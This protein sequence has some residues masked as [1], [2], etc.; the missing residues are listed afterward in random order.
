MEWPALLAVRYPNI[1]VSMDSDTDTE[2]DTS[3]TL[4][5]SSGDE[6]DDGMVENF[7]LD[8]IIARLSVFVRQ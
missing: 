6:V 2:S 5:L 4:R 8:S 3:D 7:Q 1:D